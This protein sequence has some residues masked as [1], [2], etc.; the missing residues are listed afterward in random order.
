MDAPLDKLVRRA[1]RHPGVHHYIGETFGALKLPER[2]IASY[3]T[4]ANLPG[5]GPP[6][7]MELAGLY[8]RAHRLE[9]AQELI[10]R[11]VRTQFDHP[12]APLI[13]GRV[14]RRMK[15]YDLA[16]TTFHAAIE[17]MGDDSIVG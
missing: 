5:A 17:R 3:Q 8:E 14:Q 4:A 15:Q 1:P 9:E 12:L 10:E 13:R 6:T 11:T 2:A 7:W 16:E